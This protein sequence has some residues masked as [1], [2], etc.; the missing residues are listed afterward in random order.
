MGKV[1]HYFSDISVGV[2]KLLAPLNQGDEI[3]IVGK[4]GITTVTPNANQQIIMSSASGTVGV[5]GTIVGTNQKD[6]VDLI[7]T[8]AGANT[9][10]TSANF[11]GNWTVN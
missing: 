2:I 11:V 7:C 8:T 6:C 3:R 10:W 4:L 5:T 1:S 9:V